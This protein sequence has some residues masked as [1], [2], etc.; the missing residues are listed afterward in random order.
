M[1]LDLMAPPSLEELAALPVVLH[2]FPTYGREH[3]TDGRPCWC[4]PEAQAVEGGQLI[5]HRDA[6]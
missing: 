6:N 4:A 5:V 3:V 2:V 1:T